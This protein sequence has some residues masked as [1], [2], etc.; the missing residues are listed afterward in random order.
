MHQVEGDVRIP[1]LK[2][3]S[4]DMVSQKLEN[5]DSW[6]FE[7][8]ENSAIQLIEDFAISKVTSEVHIMGLLNMKQYAKENGRQFLNR[9]MAVTVSTTIETQWQC[10]CGEMVDIAPWLLK[11]VLIT[12]TKAAEIR[13]KLFDQS[14]LS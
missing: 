1:H 9:A 6:G 7:R 14:K 8:D 11:Q 13:E 5:R 12:N 4:M 2:A 10:G 3:C